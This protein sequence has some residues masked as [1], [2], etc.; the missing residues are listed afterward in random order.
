MK[1]LQFFLTSSF[2]YFIGLSN[3]ALA[4]V[5]PPFDDPCHQ[6]GNCPVSPGVPAHVMQAIIFQHFAKGILV[7]VV[8]LIAIVVLIKMRKKK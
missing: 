5:I 6:L 4:D 2:F 8:I 3:I 7:A 1:K